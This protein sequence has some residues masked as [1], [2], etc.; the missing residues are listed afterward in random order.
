MRIFGR[1]K[2]VAC[3]SSLP[4]DKDP[5][6][7]GNIL[8]KYGFSS[9]EEMQQHVNEFTENEK[10]YLGEY[11]VEKG[12]LTEEQLAILLVRQKKMRGCP[13]TM[14]DMEVV[15]NSARQSQAKKEKEEL[16]LSEAVLRLEALNGAR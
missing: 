2:K 16:A 4:P 11:L 14:E 1:K 12:L 8:V 10:T 5:T 13:L 15:M 6:S 7:I 3:P 9:P